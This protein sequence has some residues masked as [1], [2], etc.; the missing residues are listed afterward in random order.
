MVDDGIIGRNTLDGFV[1][2]LWFQ[3][4]KEAREPFEHD[5][6]LTKAFEVQDICVEP[7]PINPTDFFANS[8]GDPDEYARLYPA[9][10]ERLPIRSSKRSDL[11]PRQKCRRRKIC[12]RALEPNRGVEANLTLQGVFHSSL[13][14]DHSNCHG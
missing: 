10:H 8:I 2:A 11:N 3:T 5:A 6:D 12:F 9:T 1:F 7:A 13:G 4:E 14:Q